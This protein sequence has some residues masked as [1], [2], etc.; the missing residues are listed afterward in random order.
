M[1]NPFYYYSMIW[2]AVLFL[3]WLNISDLYTTLSPTLTCFF[4]VNIVLFMLLGFVF[5]NVYKFKNEISN[6]N[7]ASQHKKSYLKFTVFFILLYIANFIYAKDIPLI[8][9]LFLGDTTYM[10]FQGIPTIGVFITVSNQIYGIYLISEAI[11]T[12]RKDIAIQSCAILFM[13]LLQLNRNAMILFALAF[14]VSYIRYNKI[15]LKNAIFICIFVIV[16]LYLVGGLGNIRHLASWNDSSYIRSLARINSNYPEKLPGQFIW[17][18]IYLVSPL[19]N[20]NYN[21][22]NNAS[23]FD[24]GNLFLCFIPDFIEKRLNTNYNVSIFLVD[25]HFNVPTTYA[26]SYKYGGM[27]GIIVMQLMLLAELL[28]VTDIIRRNKIK[29]KYIDV[30]VISQIYFLIMTFFQNVFRYTGTSLLVLFSV[31]LL[32]FEN[33]KLKRR[34]KFKI[35]LK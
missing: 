19:G 8:S 26:T 12:H 4:I 15:K 11:K 30:L 29:S 33:S 31:I 18:Y 25:P 3:Y 23:H 10:H 20:L 13:F 9:S 16:V 22:L 27:F 6:V 2:A 35:S 7:I 14:V 21:I 32:V 28:I 17:S 5:R 34:F 24:F 1:C